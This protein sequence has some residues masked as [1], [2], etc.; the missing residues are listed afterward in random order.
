MRKVL[1]IVQWLL[2]AL[3]LM[4]GVF[5]GGAYLPVDGTYKLYLVSAGSMAP[6]IGLGTLIAV[7]PSHQYE[8]GDVI[9]YKKAFR[10]SDELPTT[11][12]IVNTEVV[13]GEI[14]YITKGDANVYPDM[15]PVKANEIG[16]KVFFQIPYVQ[17]MIEFVKRPVGF[18][19]LILIP[20]VW[21]AADFVL[22]L[23]RQ[24]SGVSQETPN[25]T[26]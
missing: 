9:V 21:L 19:L 18:A 12:R 20:A 5:I 25:E 10:G 15:E 13:A 7:I 11:H 17:Q 22:Y 8:V 16:G 3:L 1:R 2:I 14:R 26:H 4:L 24:K 23:K 6:S